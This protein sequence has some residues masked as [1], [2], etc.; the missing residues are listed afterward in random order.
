MASK[1]ASKSLTKGA[2]A[3]T[4][5]AMAALGFHEMNLDGIRLKDKTPDAIPL[6]GRMET[7]TRPEKPDAGLETGLA[8]ALPEPTQEATTKLTLDTLGLDTTGLNEALDLYRKGDLA[9]ADKATGTLVKDDT[10]RTAIEWIVLQRFSSGFTRLQAFAKAHP[11]WPAQDWLRK[12]SEEALYNERKVSPEGRAFL[13][14]TTPKTPA[15]KIAL[16]RLMI[17][18]DK[19]QVA[20]KLVRQVW[21]ESDFSTAMEAKLKSEFGSLLEKADYKYRAERF[22]YKE[23]GAEAMRLASLAG[24][25]MVPLVRLRIASFEGIANDKLFAAV[26]ASLQNDPA[27]LF[28]RI[29]KLRRSEK[30]TEAATLMLGAPHDP[31]RLVNGDEWWVERRLIARKLLD[32]NDA[33]T[34]YKICAEHSAVSRDLRIEAEFHAGWIALRFLHDPEKAMTHFAQAAQFAE[35]PIS[36][37]RAAYWQ[38]RAAEDDMRAEVAVTANGYYG[39]AARQSATYYGQLARTKLGLPLVTEAPARH[40]LLP[41]E[42]DPSIRIIALLQ[43]LD[44]KDLAQSLSIAAAQ[45]LEGDG[46]MAALADVVDTQHDAHLAL[47][48][49]KLAGYRGYALQNLAFPTYGIPSFEP[50]PNSAARSLVYAIARQESAF[51]TKAVSS[52]GARGVMQ[53]IVSTARRTAERAGI[54]FNET[55]LLSD[56]AFNAQ[57]AAAH[58]GDLLAEQRGSWILTFAAYNAGGKKVKQWIDAYGDP[59]DPAVDPIDWVERIPFTETRNYVQRVVENL[60]MYQLRFGEDHRAFGEALLRLSPPNPVRL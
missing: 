29:Q 22:L 15:G 48:I 52:A 9:A 30:I 24:P 21:R 46:Q 44:Q 53:M 8:P 33:A 49:G 6:D 11:Q 14:E 41:A 50:L 4:I 31:A 56:A 34:A 17:L 47:M 18:D 10:V 28:A 51:D 42:Q 27:Y 12:R 1:R 43:A 35:T 25:D 55:R 13:E 45:H 57:L 19:P 2:I 59:R 5:G 26:P 58:L 40:A 7:A 16:A 60:A 39:K 38:G 54:P 3:L 36:I 23:Q 37:A 32:Q 20:A